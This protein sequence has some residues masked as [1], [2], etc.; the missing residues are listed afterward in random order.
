ML[1]APLWRDLGCC[2]RAVMVIKATAKTS[3][4]VCNILYCYSATVRTRCNAGL[5]ADRNERTLSQGQVVS[6]KELVFTISN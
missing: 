1:V 2:S 4:C 5:E 3:L 6:V